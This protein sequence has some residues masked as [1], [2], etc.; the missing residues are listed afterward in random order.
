MSVLGAS[1]MLF[2][3]DSSFYPRGWQR[4]VYVSQ[5]A[6]ATEAG[7]SEKDQAL[8]FGGNFERLFPVRPSREAEIS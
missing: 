1:R 2:G 7:I 3:T 4:G 8:I 6:A 5:M